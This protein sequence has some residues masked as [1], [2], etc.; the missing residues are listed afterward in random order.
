MSRTI[1]FAAERGSRFSDMV[2]RGGCYAQVYMV[3]ESSAS[4][5]EGPSARPRRSKEFVDATRAFAVDDP[6]RSGLHLLVVLA[7]M[8]GCVLVA[9]GPTIALPLRVL[10]SATQGLVIVRM[11]I[12]YHDF[13]HGAVLRGSRV[14]RALMYCYG[15]LVLVPPRI[16][17]ESHNYH[18]AHTAKIVGSSIGSYPMVTV[19]IWRRMTSFNRFGYRVTRHPLTILFSY[20]P[21]FMLGIC[22]TSFLRSPRKYW[23][24]GLALAV[25]AA[26]A[27][28]IARW[29]GPTTL[30]LVLV[31]PLLIAC[32]LGGYLFYAQHNFP[33]VHIQPRHQWS[34][35]DAALQ[36][37]SYIPMGPV[38][39]FVTGNIGFHH[40]HHLNPSIPFYRLPEVMRAVPELQH[41]GVT[42]L[43]LSDIWKC[44]SLKIWDAERGEMVGYPR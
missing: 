5:S 39:S 17:R 29:A 23:D 8:S 41:P 33:S 4:W 32:G 44:L 25:H 26:L 43:R 9:G 14:V 31:L 24:S 21:V 30:V 28:A 15:V 27:I 20:V 35:V 18:H 16:W 1:V 11:F 13:M 19:E 10:A 3:A 38:M 6:W 7:A 2:P 40:I 22:L 37:S 12:L 34:Y 36:S 42:S